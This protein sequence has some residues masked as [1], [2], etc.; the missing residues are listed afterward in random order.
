MWKLFFSGE[1]G[2]EVVHD[3]FRSFM[4]SHEVQCVVSPGNSFGIMDGGYDLAITEYFG[5]TLM[6]HVQEHIIEHYYG[7]QPVASSFIISIPG[8]DLRLIHTP[9]MRIPSRIKDPFIVYSCMRTTLIT[10][11]E[12]EVESIVIPAFGGLCGGVNPQDIAR[13]MREAYVSFRSLPRKIDWGYATRNEWLD[14]Y[15]ESQND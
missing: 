9:T 15:I 12:N 2:I 5:E 4:S 8:T 13:L 14:D 11:L 6:K 10:A 7:E 3:D 1:S